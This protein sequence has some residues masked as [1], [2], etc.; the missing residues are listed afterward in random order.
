M[1]V[2]MAMSNSGTS[3]PERL[4]CEY[5]ARV[6]PRVGR[7]HAHRHVADKEAAEDKRITKQ[8]DPHH[9]LAPGHAEYLLV[10]ARS[11]L[12]TPC[13][14]AGSTAAPLSITASDIRIPKPS[15]VLCKFRSTTSS[16]TARAR[17]ATGSASKSCRARMLSTDRTIVAAEQTRTVALAQT[18]MPP[19]MCT[20]MRAGQQ[21][22]KC[23][24]PD[25]S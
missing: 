7:R 23:V 25:Y 14:A 1:N 10:P 21:I 9:G 4:Q 13:F 24:R 3:L 19:R 12:T 18:Y 22:E 16:R 17:P 2:M 11:R 5:F 20:R 15:K 8:E 6:R